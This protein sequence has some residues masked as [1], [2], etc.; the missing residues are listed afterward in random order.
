MNELLYVLTGLAV[1]LGVGVVIWSF[2]D[3]RKKYYDEYKGRK[4]K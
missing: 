4:D 3:T 2:V 1:M